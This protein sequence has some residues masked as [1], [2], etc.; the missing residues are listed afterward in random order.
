M[1]L[2]LPKP[3]S[4]MPSSAGDPAYA[5]LA[6]TASTSAELGDVDTDRPMLHL[7]ATLDEAVAWC[8]G[9]ILARQTPSSPSL[10]VR[11]SLSLDFV[12]QT[13]APNFASASEAT[14]GAKLQR[15]LLEWFEPTEVHADQV[16]WREGDKPQQVAVLISGTL[17]AEDQSGA[18]Q[19]ADVQGCMLGEFGLMTGERRQN[20][21]RAITNSKLYVL[22]L[23]RWAQMQEEAPR[24]AFVLASVALKYA[25]KR[26]QHVAISA[27]AQA[28]AVPV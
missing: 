18:V 12:L 9:C 25:G 10:A 22:S 23:D 13:I 16:L 26:L 21:V 19:V 27:T 7:A 15:E 20:T 3:L 17:Q 1:A 11:P 28:N 5:G 4:G 14:D 8:E 24:L 6:K 2:V